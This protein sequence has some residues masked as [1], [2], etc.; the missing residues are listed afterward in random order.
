MGT[1]SINNSWTWSQ[2]SSVLQYALNASDRGAA[3]IFRARKTGTIDRVIIGGTRNG[4]V[5]TYRIGI[6]GVTT[7]APDGTYKSS[8]NAYVDRSTT[9]LPSFTSIAVTLGASVSVTAGDLYAVTIRHQTGTVDGSNYFNCWDG[10]NLSN[11]MGPGFPYV[12]R[13]AS[14]TWTIQTS[15]PRL[16]A[17]YSDDDVESGA[18]A[19]LSGD[20]SNNS[21]NSSGSPLYRG[22]GFTPPVSMRLARIDVLMRPASNSNFNIELWKEGDSSALLTK[23]IDP[24]ADFANT[25]GVRVA[26]YY[27]APT[28][29]NA[30]STYFIVIK[31]TTANSI[32]TFENHTYFNASGQFEMSGSMFGVTG[33]SATPPVWT[34]YNNSSDGFRSYPIMPIFDQAT[35]GGGSLVNA[36]LVG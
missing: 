35:G 8:G 31:P 11:F 6:E 7:A 4:T 10:H 36:G 18:F 34:K 32:T 29:L 19:A 24:S 1:W 21:W 5:P 23:A 27:I 3:V 9:Q 25:S 33:T 20:L 2:Q 13:L 17:L 15:V 14:S 30:N 28:T 12:S 26:R 16:V 22:I